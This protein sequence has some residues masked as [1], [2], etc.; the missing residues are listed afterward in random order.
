[1]GVCAFNLLL[2]EMINTK[3]NILFTPKTIELQTQVIE[4]QSSQK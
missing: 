1:M 3:E 2:E 4:R